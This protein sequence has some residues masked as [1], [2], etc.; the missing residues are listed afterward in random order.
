M[1]FGRS[2]EL[3]PQAQRDEEPCGDRKPRSGFM[4]AAVKDHDGDHVPY[5][6]A[7]G[8]GELRKLTWRAKG[9]H[10]KR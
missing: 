4:C 7:R 8:E 3:A 10:C 1:M 6:A 9:R 5:G 2:T